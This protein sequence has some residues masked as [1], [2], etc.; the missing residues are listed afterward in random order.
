MIL[1]QNEPLEERLSRSIGRPRGDIPCMAR[2]DL[3]DA[4]WVVLASNPTCGM[5][6]LALSLFLIKTD[7]V[8]IF[9]QFMFRKVP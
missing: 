5:S 8:K 7:V 2:P 3:L 1:G 6:F 9:S 4:K